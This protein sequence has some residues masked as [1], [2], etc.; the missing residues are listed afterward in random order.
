MKRLNTSIWQCRKCNTKFAGGAYIPK[1]D[2]ALGAEKQIQGVI[3]KMKAVET[4]EA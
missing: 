4:G 2:A 3:E 1:T